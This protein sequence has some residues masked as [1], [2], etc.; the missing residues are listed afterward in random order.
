MSGFNEDRVNRS[1]AGT[2]DGG[3]FATGDSR[4]DEMGQLDDVFSETC[5]L[6]GQPIDYCQ[7]HG[8]WNSS[9]EIAARD[10][11]HGDR[12][13]AD[14]TV[15]GICH[16]DGDMLY[17][18]DDGYEHRIGLDDTLHVLSD[19]RNDYS[20]D[21]YGVSGT[22]SQIGEGHWHV[23]LTN[24]DE[25]AR[26]DF[27]GSAEPD[28]DSVVSD[29]AANA[30]D[31]DGVTYED[32]CRNAGYEPDDDLHHEFNEAVEEAGKLRRV[33]GEQ[34]Y[35][36]IVFGDPTANSDIPTPMQDE[37]SQW[38][39][40]PDF[41]AQSHP[42]DD[43]YED[44]IEQARDTHSGEQERW[45]KKLTEIHGY[46]ITDDDAHSATDDKDWQHIA[47]DVELEDPDTGATV[48]LSYRR[49]LSTS[50]PDAGD[51]MSSYVYELGYA[52][53]YDWNA[54]QLAYELGYDDEDTDEVERIQQGFVRLREFEAFLGDR[55]DLYLGNGE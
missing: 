42:D 45:T 15:V 30:R 3:K 52:R 34:G 31:I 49:G 13:F 7:G 12:V 8:E 23:D 48:R 29:L 14:G 38:E 27:Y 35:S 16:D 6:C 20:A 32:F 53:D 40:A 5:P 22:T 44:A 55:A 11:R 50:A 54:R 39:P 17:T 26:F 10:L 47:H 24:G 25:G 1:P 33:L 41:E 19:E 18:T 2:S 4:R 46:D 43:K 9:E 28:I 51:I 36:A 21:M 37:E